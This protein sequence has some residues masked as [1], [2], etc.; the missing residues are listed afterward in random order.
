LNPGKI[1]FLAW[2]YLRQG[3]IQYLA[4]LA[5]DAP[6]ATENRREVKA[7]NLPNVSDYNPKHAV[8]D[9]METYVGFP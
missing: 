6:C 3:Y 1:E 7:P 5:Y 8:E 9:R 4:F 2:F